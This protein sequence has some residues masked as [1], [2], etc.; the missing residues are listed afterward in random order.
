MSWETVPVPRGQ[1]YEGL[2]WVAEVGAFQWVD[3][4]GASVHRWNP[5]DDLP[6]E[7]RDLDLE[8]ATVALSLD[9]DRSL[10]ASRSSLH[11]YSW[12]T[13]R[14]STIG[15]WTFD[16]DIRFNDGALAPNGDVYIGTMS[17]EGRSDV[18]ALYR[19]SGDQLI[20]VVD[21]VGISNG[22]AWASANS[23]YYVDSG[24]QSLYWLEDIDMAPRKTL[25]ARYG[26]DE[27]PDGLELDAVGDVWCAVWNGGRI[28]RWGA[29]GRLVESIGLDARRPTSIAIGGGH[30]VVTTAALEGRAGSG[31]DGAVLTMPAPVDASSEVD[32]GRARASRRKR[33]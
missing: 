21:R 14:L 24:A 10:V 18:G 20:T 2:T 5:N 9:A 31:M 19:V 1:L 28:D 25:V 15:E 33:E 6:A 16:P 8:F 23:A 30:L 11:E 17:M 4:L 7:N 22:L 12:S 29:D 27:E 32:G 3:I 13:G 26:G